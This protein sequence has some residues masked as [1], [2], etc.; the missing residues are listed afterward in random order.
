MRY[1]FL[2]NSM[3]RFCET[4]QSQEVVCSAH[5]LLANFCGRITFVGFG[6]SPRKGPKTDT[7]VRPNAFSRIAA[8]GLCRATALSS[9]FDQDA[10]RRPAGNQPPRHA[11]SQRDAASSW[12]RRRNMTVPENKPPRTAARANLQL[13]G[14]GTNRPSVL[15]DGRRVGARDND[16]HV[17]HPTSFRPPTWFRAS[18]HHRPG[19][20]H[21]TGRC[22]ARPI[23]AMAPP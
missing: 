21:L 9:R 23:P 5:R 11:F 17:G 18:S 7:I 16:G 19:L 20:C 10:V 13:R 2:L 4:R 1:R 8:P 22:Q 12:G 6:R 3:G 14:L 15:M